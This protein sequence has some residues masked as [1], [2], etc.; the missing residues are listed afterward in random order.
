MK[1]DSKCPGCNASVGDV[2]KQVNGYDLFRCPSCTLIFVP[3]ECVS[4]VN[5][6][7]LYDANAH[8]RAHVMEVDAIKDGR[9]TRFSK[10]RRLALD[11]IKE[12]QPNSLLEV[13]CGV[14]NFLSWIEMFGI[15]C[16]GVDVSEEA[17]S[18]A[19]SHLEC[20]LHAG[21]LNRAVF[22]RK[23]FEVVCAW[24]V[25]EHVLDTEE[26][27]SN[28]YERIEAKG[29]LF[30][31]TP[32]YESSWLWNDIEA[33]PRGV[34]PIHLR[35]WNERAIRNVLVRLGFDQINV[36]HCSIPLRP[37]IRS[38]SRLS[39]YLV[40]PDALFRAS[41]RRTLLVHARKT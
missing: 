20:P 31:S 34:P 30:M 25:F 13:G 2:I 24:E 29:H 28:A 18:L 38:S 15:D 27:L 6:D 1:N 39:R 41:Q 33:D 10:A 35:F 36:K 23:T 22:E 17:I 40:I 3:S 7:E 9:R 14:G 19:K 21:E 5:Y 37:A 12:L 32:N 11:M 4:S 16:C 8:Y 26:F